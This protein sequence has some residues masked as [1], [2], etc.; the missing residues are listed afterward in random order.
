MMYVMVQSIVPSLPGNVKGR[1]ITGR[2]AMGEP[3]LMTLPSGSVCAAS[4]TLNPGSKRSL[5]SPAP[6]ATHS[7]CYASASSTAR[8][9]LLG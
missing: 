2:H 6:D 3:N 5:V 4:R 9:R 1:R 8:D 7:R